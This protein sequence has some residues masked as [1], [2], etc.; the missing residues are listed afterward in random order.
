[1]KHVNNR[2]LVTKINRYLNI[3]K[4]ANDIEFGMTYL[5]NKC[6]YFFYDVFVEQIYR[7]PYCMYI[8]LKT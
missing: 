2:L 4:L 6:T 5:W 7:P 8:L 3:V 1:M